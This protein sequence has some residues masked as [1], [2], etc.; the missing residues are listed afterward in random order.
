[1]DLK[2]VQRIHDEFCKRRGWEKMRASQVFTH[3]I[4]ELS[5]IGDHILFEEG[6]KISK[7]GHEQKNNVER[8]FGQ[9]FSL[10]LQLASHFSIDLEKVFLEE[11]EDME[12]R[13]DADMWRKYMGRSP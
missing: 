4:Q 6:Y 13:F 8:E 9:A 10:F 2:K 12:R 11:L 5:E 3:L 7:L 1:M